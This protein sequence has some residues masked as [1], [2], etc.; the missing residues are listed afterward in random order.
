MENNTT[1]DNGIVR[2]DDNFWE[3]SQTD[4]L[5]KALLG[6]NSEFHSVK[7][8][9][10][11]S[12]QGR[13]D[14][15]FASL[16]EIMLVIRPI[17]AKHKLYIQQPIIGNRLV[18]I[19]KHEDGQFRA[20]A[21]PMVEWQGQ[22]TNAL[23]NLGGAITYLKRYTISAALALATEEDDD[24]NS[25][26]KLD[27]KKKAE[28][29]PPPKLDD[30]VVDAWQSKVNDCKLPTDFEA[31]SKEVKGIEN[32]PVKKFIRAAMSKRMLD[33]GVE[34]VKNEAG[35]GGEFKKIVKPATEK[36]A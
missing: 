24:G 36:Q 17:L 2:Y 13:K 32:E 1:S 11:V 4:K 34:F 14:R 26:G 31:L 27:I 9:E 6:F 20:F 22:G 12:V 29:V 8:D 23:Q 3:T 28:P 10:T 35:D 5:D 25:A 16:D 7:R 19:V 33:V 30:N 15:K 18:T 21:M